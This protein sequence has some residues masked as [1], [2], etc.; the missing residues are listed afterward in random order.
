MNS[1]VS[2]HFGLNQLFLGL[3]LSLF[4][5][6]SRNKINIFLPLDEVQMS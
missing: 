2:A 6:L 5:L 4:F 1:A 3:S